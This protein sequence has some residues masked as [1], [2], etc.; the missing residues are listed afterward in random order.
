[1]VSLLHRSNVMP[2]SLNNFTRTFSNYMDFNS[3]ENFLDIESEL[4]QL[5]VGKLVEDVFHASFSNW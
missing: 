1:M 4:N 5:I 2:D 3:S